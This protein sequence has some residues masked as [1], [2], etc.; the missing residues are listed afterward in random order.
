MKVRF[1][2][3]VL[4]NRHTDGAGRPVHFFEAIHCHPLIVRATYAR[5]Y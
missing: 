1:A 4:Q 5:L 3:I 2:P